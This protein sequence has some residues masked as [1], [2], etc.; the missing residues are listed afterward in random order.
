MSI[1]KQL[2][3]KVLREVHPDASI[4]SESIEWLI[5]LFCKYDTMS[6]EQIINDLSGQL[7]NHAIKYG[8]REK[9]IEYILAEILELSGNCARD[10]HMNRITVLHLWIGILSDAELKLLFP[11]PSV[12]LIPIFDT[13]KYGDSKKV[14]SY[15]LHKK[16]LKET[17]D[18]LMLNSDAKMV[19]YHTVFQCNMY[20]DKDR[21]IEKILSLGKTYDANLN[22]L[23]QLRLI[24][25][26]LLKQKLTLLS[27]N[28]KTITFTDVSKTIE[29][30]V[31]EYGSKY[32]FLINND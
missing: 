28:N 9:V 26:D 25:L 14:K 8:T 18:N 10:N 16:L 3:K 19:L 11:H 6:R 17:F 13:T 15:H 24:V 12:H 1:N 20:Y 5:K 32:E 30:I 31:L 22:H 23:E 7:V 4:T 29:N 27:S 2:I 21:C